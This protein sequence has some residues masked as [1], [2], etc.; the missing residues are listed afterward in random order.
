VQ[1]FEDKEREWAAS[2]AASE[3]MHAQQLEAARQQALQ[4]VQSL[5][6]AHNLR[7]H[8]LQLEHE[9]DVE[10]LLMQV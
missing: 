3:E 6:V 5:E 2:V 4:D 10:A 8:D 9:R 7:L 1:E